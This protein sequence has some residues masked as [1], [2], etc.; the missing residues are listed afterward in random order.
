MRRQP[1]VPPVA[2]LY[3]MPVRPR[4]VGR[5]QVPPTTYQHAMRAT[6]HTR[7]SLLAASTP[8]RLDVSHRT[9]ALACCGVRAPSLLSLPP[10]LP[11]PFLQVL[12]VRM[13]TRT[14]MANTSSS[15]A[16]SKRSA[17]P[18]SSPGPVTVV[19]LT[20]CAAAASRGGQGQ[21][22]ESA[23]TEVRQAGREPSIIISLPSGAA[24][25]WLAGWL[26]GLTH[27][28]ACGCGCGA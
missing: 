20:P 15:S 2:S 22:E 3:P 9:P 12:H 28:P 19:G 7:A 26:V 10:S 23:A 24:P 21:E 16:S 27:Q 5:Y 18:S 4:E 17:L 1:G 14:P 11:R 8:T 6:I 13:E 25:P